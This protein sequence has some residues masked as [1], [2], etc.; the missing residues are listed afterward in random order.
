MN[1]SVDEMGR[2][3][4]CG[5]SYACSGVFENITREKLEYFIKMND[6]KLASSVST[7]TNYLIIGKILDD[8]RPVTESGKYKTRISSLDAKQRRTLQSRHL[9]ISFNTVRFSQV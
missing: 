6:G 9:T 8:N 2:G 1:L 3:P 4:L 7:K 5:L